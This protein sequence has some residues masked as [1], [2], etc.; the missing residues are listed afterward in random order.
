ME[1]S[2]KKLI[3]KGVLD[4]ANAALLE[5]LPEG[6]YVFLISDAR[7]EK[8]S[9]A[10]GALTKSFFVEESSFNSTPTLAYVRSLKPT[11]EVAAVVAIGG[12]SAADVGKYVATKYKLPLIVLALSQATVGYL[13][14]SAM[15]DDNGFIETYKT[16]TPTLL[17]CDE[18]FLTQDE[19]LTAAGFGDV[20]SRLCSLFDYEAASLL[21]GEGF[22]RSVKKELL[23][24]VGKLLTTVE[25]GELTPIEMSKTVIAASETLGKIGTSRLYCGGEAQL[26]RAF[27]LMK[28][29]ASAD[30][31]LWGE[32]A[33]LLSSIALRSY[34]AFLSLA[35]MHPQHVANNN[36]RLDRMTSAL[37]LSAPI[38]AKKL[39]PLCDYATVD[40]LIYA[41]RLY[42]F[43]L[44]STALAYEKTLCFAISRFKRL[45]N[46]RGYSYNRY[47]TSDE[48]RACVMLAP[49]MNEKFTL[50]TAMKQAGVIG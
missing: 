12:G 47:M 22:D 39:S 10:R 45:Y 4:A 20:C 17:V 25:K 36:A 46:D 19:R 14:P 24:I 6:S 31:R 5:R 43:E 3:G 29:R 33:L 42:R 30:S 35:A 21:N 9:E 50:F 37:G 23:R 11:S 8:S 38:A 13:I 48:L 7:F 28:K 32:N 41:L 27:G 2:C 15:L 40:K 44:T 18:N 1:K 49:E 16:I 26:S 34:L